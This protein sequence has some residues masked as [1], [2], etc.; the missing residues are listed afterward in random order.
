MSHSSSARAQRVAVDIDIDD[1]I[2]SFARA[3][4][5]GMSERPRVLPCRFLYDA[6]GS[7][8]FEQICDLPEYYL[9]RTET[10]IL[11]KHSAD[12]RELTG[13][14]TMIELGSGFSTKTDYLLQAYTPNES[15]L[16]YVPVDVSEFAIRLAAK[17][18]RDRHPSVEVAGIVGTYESA[19]PLFKKHSPSMVVFLGS[20]IGNFEPNEAE[21]FWCRVQESL[22][23]GD[24]FLLG[25]DL[26][27]DVATLEAAYNDSSGLTAE[28]MKNV[29]ARM[30]RELGSDI[31]LDAIE[32]VA[33]YDEATRQIEISAN[34]A[35]DQEIFIEPLDSSI[36]VSAG[37]SVMLEVSRKFVLDELVKYL[38][39]YGLD[40]KQIFTDPRPWFAEL[41][42][43][44]V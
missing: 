2:I 22:L 11:A 18:I 15:N 41:L 32:H 19:F 36:A 12:I 28:F 13:P 26:V 39:N 23:P 29:F 25:V 34:F 8:L 42:L 17:S 38:S 40:T 1:P 37:E 14:V 20:T 9:T 7:E 35:R 21:E 5:A 43:Q 30:N 33:I 10:Q 3:V 31:D 6:R 27:K 24:F 44:R 4:E 16:K